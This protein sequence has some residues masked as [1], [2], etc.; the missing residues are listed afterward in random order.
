MKIIN[1]LKDYIKNRLIQSKIDEKNKQNRS[2]NQQ[3][4]QKEK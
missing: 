4:E 2:D 1:A 3:N